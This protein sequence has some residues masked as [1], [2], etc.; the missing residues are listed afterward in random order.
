[1][2]ENI[3][4]NKTSIS[5]LRL[6]IRFPNQQFSVSDIIEETGLGAGNV[7]EA[8]KQLSFEKAIKKDRIIGKATYRFIT[9]NKMTEILNELFSEEKNRAFLNKIKDY[10][11]ISEIEARIVQNIGSNLINIILFGSYA[12]GTN[13]QGSDIDICII[14]R[15][16]NE[17]AELKLR[18][19]LMK[20]EQEVQTHTFTAEK[21][22]KLKN[23][24]DPLIINILK[25][26][27]MLNICT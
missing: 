11:L 24:K 4:A 13:T 22:L 26:G 15:K 25:D 3:L 14:V 9:D 27:L 21:F 8:L 12:K 16:K 1:M 20:I 2:I 18:T 10:K 23:A 17:K 5:I 19:N 7:H 6:L